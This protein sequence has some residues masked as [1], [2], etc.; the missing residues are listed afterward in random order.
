M[1]A[2]GAFLTSLAAAAT[3]SL[4][5]AV[6]LAKLG[7]GTVVV[8]VVS[9]SDER[10]ALPAAPLSN[11]LLFRCQLVRP[12]FD[13]SVPG[14]LIVAAGTGAPRGRMRDQG[15][16]PRRASGPLEGRSARLA[17]RWRRWR[18]GAEASLSPARRPRP[19][20][21]PGEVTPHRNRHPQ[22]FAPATPSQ[23]RWCGPDFSS[24]RV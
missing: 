6:V 2:A 3:L 9:V 23:S 15:A 17:A 8:V 18:P 24:P 4:G 19:P 5:P 10:P 7:A 21:L 11:F 22:A 13:W 16:M 12:R 1:R 14:P 20:P